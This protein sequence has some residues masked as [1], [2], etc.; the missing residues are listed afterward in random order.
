MNKTTRYILATVWILF[1]RSF[2]AYA[3][4]Q[5]TPDLQKEASPLVAVLGLDWLPLLSLLALFVAYVLFAYWRALFGSYSIL[6]AEKGLNLSEFTGYLATG[7]KTKWWALLYQFP[8]TRAHF[9]AYFGYLLTICLSVAGVVST[10][11]W[12]LIWYSDAY[13]NV[14]SVALIYSVILGGCVLAVGLWLRKLYTGYLQQRVV[15]VG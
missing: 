13:R 5:H 15:E 8:K 7:R 9:H 2:D 12:V 11:M 3:T 14:H 6:P 1:S 10:L 4:W